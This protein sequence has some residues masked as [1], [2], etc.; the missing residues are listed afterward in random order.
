MSLHRA[1]VDESS[2]V[3][4]GDMQEYLIA[5]AVLPTDSCEGVR[6]ALRPL[7][8]PGQIKLHWTDESDRRRRK[9]V[10]GLLELQPMS[11]IVTHLSERRKKNERY[12]RLCLAE[13]YN[14]MAAMEVHDLLL[15]SRS[16]NQDK[17]DKAHIVS[18]Q[19]AGLDRRLRITH[20]RG[21][22]EPLLWIA[23]AVLGAINAERAGDAGYYEAL[24][25]TFLINR[26]TPT[27][28]VL[29]TSERP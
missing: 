24:S 15:E 12:R 4:G 18:L 20:E 19:N 1:F 14:E 7:L 5:A 13:L 11:V 9:I 8:L 25:S 2:A 6:A 22:E 29:Q 26:P 27:S 16:T 23:D 3:R 17:G 10:D 21:G 28:V